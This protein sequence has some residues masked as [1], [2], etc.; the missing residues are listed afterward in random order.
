MEMVWKGDEG[1][2][3]CRCFFC[4][5][6]ELTFIPQRFTKNLVASSLGLRDVLGASIL[7]DLT[8]VVL[9][10]P[11]EGVELGH[12]HGFFYAG[13]V[14]SRHWVGGRDATRAEGEALRYRGLRRAD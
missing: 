7:L 2:I 10:V 3:K 14:D 11:S 8:V 6:V 9:G 13:D 12:L 5:T 4:S 1:R